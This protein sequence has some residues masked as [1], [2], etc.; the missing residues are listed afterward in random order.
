MLPPLYTDY[1]QACGN[2]S[3]TKHE[4]DM[5]RHWTVSAVS[6]LCQLLVKAE[7]RKAP[8]SDLDS[9]ES[10]MKRLVVTTYL[11][12]ALI[13]PSLA[14]DVAAV[15]KK[16]KQKQSSECRPVG[17]VKGTKLWAGNCIAPEPMAAP[18]AGPESEPETTGAIRGGK[19]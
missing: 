6:F 1:P 15:E 7:R 14:Q 5:D 4:H 10:E 16:A 11:M 13:G 17:T 9:R 19:E 12:I 2:R 3:A 18:V 8:Q